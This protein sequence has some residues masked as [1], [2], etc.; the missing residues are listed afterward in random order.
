MTKG[1]SI[2]A[3]G[4]SEVGRQRM[5]TRMWRA[6]LVRWW[7]FAVPRQ[8]LKMGVQL[9]QDVTFYGMPIISMAPGSYISIGD[10]CVL[11]SDSRFTALGVN[12]PVVLRTTQPGASIT[13]GA[14]TGM[15]GGTICAA[16]KVSV[17]ERCLLGANI[18]IADTDFHAIEPTNRRYN[19]NPDSVNTARVEIGD[20]VFIGTQAIILK[21]VLVGPGSLIGAG[22]VISRSV[23][24]FTIAANGPQ[25]ELG[26]TTNTTKKKLTPNGSWETSAFEKMK[27]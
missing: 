12:H 5:F 19:N 7:R 6:V 27:P 8:L 1:I 26:S 3:Q 22:A 13:I 23:P 16:V 17:G 20:D 9:G 15:S 11:C 2:S 14:D 24:S 25:R 10:R 21:G 4:R 18:L